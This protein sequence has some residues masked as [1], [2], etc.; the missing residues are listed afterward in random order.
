MECVS[1]RASRSGAAQKRAQHALDCN[2]A[3]KNNPHTSLHASTAI[4]WPTRETCGL[5][6]ATHCCGRTR[7]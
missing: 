7:A 3:Q 5:V 4:C 1:D 2:A 6:S